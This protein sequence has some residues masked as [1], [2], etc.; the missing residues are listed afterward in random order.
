MSNVGVNRRICVK[1]PEIVMSGDIKIST[2]I[3]VST[4]VSYPPQ[5]TLM[6]IITEFSCLIVCF[7]PSL[8]KLMSADRAIVARRL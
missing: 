2:A 6:H 4:K 8:T 5:V 7:R 3:A 1:A